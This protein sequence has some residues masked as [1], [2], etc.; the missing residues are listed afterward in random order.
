MYNCKPIVK[1][2]TDSYFEDK[3]NRLTTF[4]VTFWRPILCEL[5]RHR[6]FSYCFRSSRA[7]P[8]KK[9]IEEARENTWGPAHWGKN[10]KG[11]VAEEYYTYNLQVEEFEKAWQQSA[12]GNATIATSFMDVNIHKQVVNRLLEPYI[13]VTG[14]VSGT[15]WDNFFNLRCSN[16]AQPEMRDLAVAM[17]EALENSEPR[18]LK[19]NEWHLPYITQVEK[20]QHELYDLVRASTA[21]CARVSYNKFDGTTSMQEDCELYERLAKAGHMS[22]L[23]FV[24][25]P[26]KGYILSNYKTP[27]LQLRKMYETRADLRNILQTS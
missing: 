25:T 26:S 12:K 7:T 11:M 8:I 1:V 27:W 6:Q 14:L 22:P 5:T 10:C 18:E 17:K 4:E 21:R 20:E 15:T 2:L 19:E 13:S 24:A 23:E 16:D 9:L 3:S